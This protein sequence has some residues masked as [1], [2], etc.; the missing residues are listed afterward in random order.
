[1]PSL[2]KLANTGTKECG[3]CC[4]SIDRRAK[5]CPYC[6]SKQPSKSAMSCSG[7]ILLCLLGFCLFSTVVTQHGAEVR[8]KATDANSQVQTA[9]DQAIGQLNA[10]DVTA[11]QDT[12][13]RAHA[14][15]QAT[16][17]DSVNLWRDRIAHS[18]DANY[19]RGKL[20]ELPDADFARLKSQ[21]TLPPSLQFGAKA[22]GDRAS[23]EIQKLMKDAPALEAARKDRQE[24]LAFEEEER[25]QRAELDAAKAK[26]A[27]AEAA[28]QK[29]AQRLD[30]EKDEA[31]SIAR[32]FVERRLKAPSTASWPGIF[33]DRGTVVR[34][35]D[36][37]YEVTSWV[38]SQNSFGAKLR[39]HYA[40]TVRHNA[41]D[42][43]SLM[44]FT[45]DD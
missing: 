42:N 25:K 9:V 5:I 39:M 6:R 26:R 23:T 35:G 7:V 33:D 34:I 17:F 29:E 1:M 44:S 2:P 13:D 15:P 16:Q 37:V 11:A 12:L 30:E 20:L 32:Q 31:Y 43:W 4:Q 14:I 28:R 27:A 36:G 21:N 10:G 45:S 40:A 24:K 3:K 19:L 22:L 18:G 38:D 8:Q 41:G